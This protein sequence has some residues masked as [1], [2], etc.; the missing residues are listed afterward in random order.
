MLG[1]LQAARSAEFI[2][3]SSINGICMCRLLFFT[4]D[5]SRE[6]CLIREAGCQS[7]HGQ[8]VEVHLPT[9]SC[10]DGLSKS[11]KTKSE[12]QQRKSALILTMRLLRNFSPFLRN[13]L[14]LSCFFH[15]FL[16]SPMG[17]QQ[18]MVS[19][20]GADY[21]EDAFHHNFS[22]CFRN[23]SFAQFYPMLN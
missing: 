6:Q 3:F 15:N 1:S 22:G 16:R 2:D 21:H 12:I 18:M 4:Q 17:R 20:I 10:G 5:L 9:P 11:T 8:P 14:T 23:I 7:S 13:F 19:R